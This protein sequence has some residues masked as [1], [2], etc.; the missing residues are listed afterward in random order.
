VAQ[1]KV[2]HYLLVR[3]EE[4][5]IARAQRFKNKIQTIFFYQTRFLSLQLFAAHLFSLL[6]MKK[7]INRF[8]RFS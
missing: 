8:L 7:Y 3:P 5:A 4:Y 6:T 2:A 1:V